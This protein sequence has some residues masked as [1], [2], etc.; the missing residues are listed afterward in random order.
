M[1]DG[2]T[3]AVYCDFS[4]VKA[5]EIE[6]FKG[7]IQPHISDCEK[8]RDESLCARVLLRYMLQK[9]FGVCDF[10]LAVKENGKPYL[11][12]S[13]LHF[14]F[15]HCLKRVICTVSCAEVGCD[16]QDIRPLNE[17][18]TKRFFATKEFQALSVSNKKDEHF[19]KLWALKEAILKYK[20]DGISGGLGY[21]SFPEFLLCDSFSAYGCNFRSFEKDGFI[22]GICS[23]ADSITV[24]EADI[25]DILKNLM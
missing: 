23:S 2:K 15:S 8:M 17:K 6:L 19:T 10:S 25:K 18:V 9:Y 16:V 5:D 11:V 3:I 12:N 21:Y 24:A 4:A 13:D 7:I 20:G 14:N 1:A 22:Y